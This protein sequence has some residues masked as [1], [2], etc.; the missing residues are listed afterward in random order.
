MKTIFTKIF[1][2]S[3]LSF[4]GMAIAQNYPNDNYYGNNNYGNNGYEYVCLQTNLDI[5]Q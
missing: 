2:A 5:L 4:A 3:A 1:L